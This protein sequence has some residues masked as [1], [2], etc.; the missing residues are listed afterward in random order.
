MEE[1]K[2]KKRKRITCEVGSDLEKK[3]KK[4]DVYLQRRIVSTD[5]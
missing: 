5:L 4:R 3:K 2:K 1:K